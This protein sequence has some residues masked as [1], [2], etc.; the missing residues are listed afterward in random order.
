M[1]QFY[2]ARKKPRM[3][4]ML[5]L[6][7]TRLNPNVIIPLYKMGKSELEEMIL[8]QMEKRGLSHADGTKVREQAEVDYEERIKVAEA[9]KE[10]RRRLHEQA[11]FPKLKHGG[12]KP[13]RKKVL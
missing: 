12:L 3:A 8:A 5:P 1:T 6:G 13:L 9:R 10:L 4:V 11:E 2:I 7:G